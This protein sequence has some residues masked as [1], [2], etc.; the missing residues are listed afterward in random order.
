M[1]KNPSEHVLVECGCLV[2]RVQEVPKNV[3]Y[4]CYSD[5]DLNEK[6]GFSCHCACLAQRRHPLFT[7]LW[8][9]PQAQFLHPQNFQ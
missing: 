4:L 1:I 8:N 6:Q 3:P 7:S 9:I 5:S 2:E